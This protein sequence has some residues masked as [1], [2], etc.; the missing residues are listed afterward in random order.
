MAFFVS[1]LRANE[2]CIVQKRPIKV[3]EEESIKII[4]G[5]QDGLPDCYLYRCR[6]QP[7]KSVLYEY[8]ETIYSSVFHNKS[9]F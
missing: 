6:R 2:K 5:R 9:S 8:P 3:S 7:Q 1:D 4:G